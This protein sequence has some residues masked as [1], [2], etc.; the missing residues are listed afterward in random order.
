MQ[1]IRFPL[2]SPKEFSDLVLP[3]NFLTQEEIILV[4]KSFYSDY[5]DV[6]APMFEFRP[7]VRSAPSPP[8]LS[9]TFSLNPLLRTSWQYVLESARLSFEVS[10]PIL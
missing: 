6:V 3:K 7:R 4:F 5:S 10:R 2:M 8:M 9:F 1:K